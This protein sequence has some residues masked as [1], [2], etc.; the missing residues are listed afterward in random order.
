MTDFHIING[1]DIV[2]D[3]LAFRML[4]DALEE[5]IEDPESEDPEIKLADD[6]LCSMRKAKEKALDIM[7]RKEGRNDEIRVSL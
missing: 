3:A 1:R 4:E 2:A 7:K 6:F 5:F